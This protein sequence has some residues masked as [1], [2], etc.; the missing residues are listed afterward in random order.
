MYKKVCPVCKKEFL[1]H[2]KDQI[3]CCNAC[4]KSR[5]IKTCPKCG[6]SFV[7]YNKDQ[8]YCSIKCSLQN[9]IDRF[10]SKVKIGSSDDCWEWQGGVNSTGRGVYWYNGSSIHAHRFVWTITNGDI[11]DNM[12]VCHHCDNG[13]CVNPKHLFLGTQKD[14]MQDMV[15][16]GRKVTLRGSND[17]KSKLTESDVLRIRSLYGEYSQYKL[18]RMFNVSRSTISAIIHRYNWKHV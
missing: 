15:S 9:P 17:P 4:R 11:P 5:H 7:T 2:K 3:H 12:L 1:T 14:N 18:A 8:T 16:K 10:W 13:K 6:N